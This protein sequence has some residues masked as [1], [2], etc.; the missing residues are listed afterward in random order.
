MVALQHFRTTAAPSRSKVSSARESLAA[1]VDEMPSLCWMAVECI[2]R[3][4]FDL[5]MLNKQ[6]E[7]KIAGGPDGPST[8]YLPNRLN[9]CDQ[10]PP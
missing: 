9:D 1:G 3:V 5:A 6:P 8:V 10:H 4:A 7:S 2:W